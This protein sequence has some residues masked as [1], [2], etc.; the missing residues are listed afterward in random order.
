MLCMK[1]TSTL[2]G[3]KK[4]KTNRYFQ[5]GLVNF[6]NMSKVNMLVKTKEIIVNKNTKLN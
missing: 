4:N 6:E 5:L 2:Y 3:N 1:I